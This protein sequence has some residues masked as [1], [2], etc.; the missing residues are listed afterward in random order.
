MKMNDEFEKEEETA[1]FPVV[2]AQFKIMADAAPVLIWL[3]GTDKLCYF[4]NKSWLMFTGRTMQQEIGN[5]WAEG[6]Y[7]E[8]FDK[9]QKT[10]CSSFDLRTDFKMEYRLRD[11]NGEYRWLLNHGVPRYDSLGDFSGYIGSCVDI[12]EQVKAREAL[13][14]V[15]EE[16]ERRV[17]ERVLDLKQANEKLAY[18]NYELENFASIASHDLQEPLRKITIF[19]SRLKNG[20][21]NVIDEAGNMYLN[22]MLASAESMKGLIE[23]LLLFSQID[24]AKEAC[25]QVDLNEVLKKALSYLEIKIEETA[26]VINSVQLPV[27]KANEFQM[28]QLFLNLINNALKFRKPHAKPEITISCDKLP[29]EVIKELS[30]TP[31]KTYFEISVKDNGIGFN[32]IYKDKIFKLFQRLHGKKE[33]PGTGLGLA[34]CKKIIDN[35]KGAMYVESKPGKGSTFSVVLPKT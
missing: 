29:V 18:S 20:F 33:Y 8:D 6:I 7:K 13:A 19:G 15:N 1:H 14:S 22:R 11:K 31:E 28:E 35:H 25:V 27:I 17:Q 3:A 30:L 12:D 9:C 2:D 23:N 4:F 24:R 21:T 34:I 32:E 26:A 10:Y 16:L 5:G